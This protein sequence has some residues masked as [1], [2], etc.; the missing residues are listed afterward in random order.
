MK[1]QQCKGG[2][3]L[4]VRLLVGTLKVWQFMNIIYL[5]SFGIYTFD[6]KT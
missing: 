5:R 3:V 4:L 1:N 2:K 6:D